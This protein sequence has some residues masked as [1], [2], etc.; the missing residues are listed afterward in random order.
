MSC[1]SDLFGVTD[2]MGTIR[3][4]YPELCR[5]PPSLGVFPRCWDMTLQR[6]KNKV[7]KQLDSKDSDSISLL[8]TCFIFFSRVLYK[9]ISFDP[10]E[11][12]VATISYMTYAG[13]C[14][15]FPECC[16]F[17]VNLLNGL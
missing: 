12:L 8:L 16:C 9:T 14:S 7:T 15:N 13:G 1:I 4:V 11:N 2:H 17:L 3:G 6:V 10:H 5:M